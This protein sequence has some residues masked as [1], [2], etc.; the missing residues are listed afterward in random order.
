MLH[1]NMRK[2]TTDSGKAISRSTFRRKDVVAVN[3]DIC[4][5][6]TWMYKAVKEAT[7][8]AE[9]KWF[10]DGYVVQRKRGVLSLSWHECCGLVLSSEPQIWKFHVVIWQTT[11]KHCI[12]KRAARAAR[13]FFFIQPINHWFVALSLTLPSSNLKLPYVRT[14]TACRDGNTVPLC[15]MTFR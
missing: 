13:L 15:K 4:R 10:H 12:K 7:T 8:V 11:S 6:L 5:H 1:M 9:T 3:S 2:F 14:R